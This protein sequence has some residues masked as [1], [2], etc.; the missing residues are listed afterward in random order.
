MIMTMM[1]IIMM[2]MI[3]MIMTITIM[4]IISIIML[5]YSPENLNHMR[6]FLEFYN[7]HEKTGIISNIPSQVNLL[8]KGVFTKFKFY[9]FSII[10]IKYCAVINQKTVEEKDDIK[11]I[12]T[13]ISYCY[14]ANSFTSNLLNQLL[15][16]TGLFTLQTFS[17]PCSL[18]Y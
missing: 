15:S 12:I 11:A 7:D 3:L 1:L 9:H 17:V 10:Q 8:K 13:C 18:N 4:F 2:I 5:I 6:I 14:R 16:A